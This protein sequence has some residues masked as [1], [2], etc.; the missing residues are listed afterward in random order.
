MELYYN[1]TLYKL[2]NNILFE[3][4]S[5][6]EDIKQIA[7]KNIDN[8]SSNDFNKLISFINDNNLGDK[9]VNDISNNLNNIDNKNIIKSLDNTLNIIQNFSIN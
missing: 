3:S 2:N 8:I 7:N 9:I 4:D 6:T 1:N 5:N